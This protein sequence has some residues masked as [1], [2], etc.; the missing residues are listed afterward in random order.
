MI[1]ACAYIWTYNEEDFISW[2]IWNLI[3]NGI[4]IHVFDNWSTD[5]TF[6]IV[7]SF[8]P[9]VKLERYPE[10]EEQCTSLTARLQ[11]LEEISLHS[12]YDW[13]INHDADEIR[14]TGGS[15]KMIEFIDR[16]DRR[17]F[18]AIDH[19]LMVFAPKEGWTGE[20]NPESFF[21]NQIK[22]AHVDN[23]NPHIKC[24][25]RG[26][27][28]VELVSS[29]GH[30]AKFDGRRVPHQKLLLKH[31]PLRTQAHADRK[32]AERQRSY[33]EQELANGWHV[34]Y[35]QKWW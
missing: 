10:H 7:Q 28:K 31:Y 15:E 30:Q 20:Q 8:G 19:R 11:S 6:E 35:K 29:G 4:A 14:S 2:T 3:N 16:V 12:K 1:S 34:Q 33:A 32:L 27:N 25:K 18:T 26:Q 21:T 22:S 9:G 13:I 24:W 5:R 17:G 23:I